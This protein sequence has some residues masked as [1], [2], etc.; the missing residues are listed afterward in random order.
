MARRVNRTELYLDISR[1]YK[2]RETFAE[3]EKHMGGRSDW[4]KAYFVV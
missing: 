2:N 3:F 4:E 1:L